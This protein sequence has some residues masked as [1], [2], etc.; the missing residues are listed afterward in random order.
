M[1]A[2]FGNENNTQ[3][4][5]SATRETQPQQDA[6]R[7]DT[8]ARPSSIGEFNALFSNPMSQST[9]GESV[10]TFAEAIRGAIKAAGDT[11]NALDV[12]T[13]DGEES[14][15][16]LSAVLVTA[17]IGSVVAV[18]TVVI[19][20]SGPSLENQTYSTYSAGP[21]EVV[22]DTVPGDVCDKDFWDATLYVV[23]SKFGTAVDIVDAGASVIPDACSPDNLKAMQSVTYHAVTAAW[24]LASH[25]QAN[26]K[27]ISVKDISGIASMFKARIDLNAGD[28]ESAAGLPVRNDFNVAM[29]GISGNQRSTS[30]KKTIALTSVGGFLDLVYN[31]SNPQQAV[32]QNPYAPQPQM[33]D[34]R[35]YTPRLVMTNV[36]TSLSTITMELQLLAISTATL[37]SH[38]DAWVNALRPSSDTSRVDMRDI[39][40][41]GLEVNFTNSPDHQFAKIDTKA[42]TF[43]DNELYALIGASIHPNLIYSLDVEEAGEMSWLQS[44]LVAA[45][46]GDNESIDFILRSADNL[47]NGCF[48]QCYKGGS[49]VE[50]EVNRVQLGTYTDED[51]VLRDI[52]DLDYLAV[53]NIV[54]ERDPQVVECFANTYDRTEI[55]PAL[56]LDDRA[57][58]IRR[59]LGDTVKITGYANRITFNTEFLIALATAIHNAG[60]SP[61]PENHFQRRGPSVRGNVNANRY[62]MA[63]GNIGNMW[64]QSQGPVGAGPN[65]TMGPRATHGAW[66]G[67]GSY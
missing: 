16:A 44:I 24:S 9:L 6:P 8:T 25:S 63:S 55:D 23:R 28:N 12:L 5:Q 49:P 20:S 57:N 1:A 17:R 14:N 11:N 53:M 30:A 60:L 7:R 2:N 27:A 51:G 35:T 45:A 56:R 38:N 41:V 62:G 37:M 61:Q 26:N 3:K 54:G 67:R 33:P 32:L 10:T 50:S 36:R 43:D 40:A 64:Q 46:Q 34:A 48:S 18:H 4:T 15:M 42:S 13:L 22:V 52:R 66:G 47:T 21:R 31:P 39:G 29:Y 19:E 65:Y 59:V 58:I